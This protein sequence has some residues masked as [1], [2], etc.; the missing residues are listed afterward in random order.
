MSAFTF[1]AIYLVAA[2]ETANEDAAEDDTNGDQS[3]ILILNMLLNEISQEHNLVRV[4]HL[5]FFSVVSLI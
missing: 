4:L 1:G 3:G 5:L 2:D